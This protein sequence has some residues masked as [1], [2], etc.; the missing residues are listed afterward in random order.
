MTESSDESSRMFAPE[1]KTFSTPVKISVLR[2][3]LLTRI[4]SRLS[5]S[6][7]VAIE[8]EFRDAGRLKVTIVVKGERLVRS[9]SP[10][11][12]SIVIREVL[13]SHEETSQY[14]L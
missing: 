3:G 7:S 5:S 10:S 11:I 1:R 8:S 9:R 14:F 13:R 2:A 4:D 12:H 6:D